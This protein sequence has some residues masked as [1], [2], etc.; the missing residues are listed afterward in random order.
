MDQSMVRN[1]VDKI[2]TPSSQLDDLVEEMVEPHVPARMPSYHPTRWPIVN[3]MLDVVDSVTNGR[4]NLVVRI[5]S[6]LFFG[7]TAAIVNLIVFYI[8]LHYIPLHFGPFAQTL[9]A[10]AL[11]CEISLIANFVP[12]DY[13]TF[14]HL[15]GR[16]R[17][18]SARCARFH[19]TS[20]V[21][22]GLTIL[23]QLF[24]THVIH[25]DALLSQATALILVL[26]YNYSFHHLFTYRTVK[27]AVV[28][29]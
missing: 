14:R 16:T 23:L 9:F 29:H 17:S 20:L 12:N 11:A 22:T 7:G 8:A 26:F 3:R 2:L 18:W 28:A 6:Y 4:A 15:A 21:G 27:P 24:F 10:S 19:V 25:M 13:F 1:N 5:I